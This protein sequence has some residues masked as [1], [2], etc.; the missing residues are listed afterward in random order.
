ML[1][2]YV[3]TNPKYYFGLESMRFKSKQPME[4]GVLLSAPWHHNF[5]HWMIEILPRLSMYERCPE[6]HHLPLILPKSSRGFVSGSLALSG[7]LQK[8]VF[9]PDG[10]YRFSRL[11]LLAQLASPTCRVSPHAIDWLDNTIGQRVSRGEC[12]RRIY[13]SRRDANIRYVSN[14][15]ELEP[16][17]AEFGFTTMSMS[18]VPLA[19]QIKLL[20]SAECVVGPHGAAF[21]HLAFAEPGTKFIEFFPP[22]HCTVNFNRI[23]GIK[24]IRYG[25]LVG[26]HAGF[27]GYSVDPSALRSVLGQALG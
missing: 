17:L 16:V 21:A 25:F 22:E 15:S 20:R 14:E 3:V 19:S 18:G 4:E 7:Y 24:K 13:I 26:K 11:H 9:L 5:F 8:V 6:L 12:P 1:A 23:C 2:P 10:A 27:G